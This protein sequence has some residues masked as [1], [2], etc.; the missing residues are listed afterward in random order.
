LI[1][2]N[3]ANIIFYLYKLGLLLLIIDHVFI[4]IKFK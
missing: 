1:Y 2:N 4:I 3:L